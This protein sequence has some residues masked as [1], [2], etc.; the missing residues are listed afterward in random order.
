MTML[1]TR[2]SKQKTW[3]LLYYRTDLH[4]N[5]FSVV[6][7]L[8]TLSSP[9]SS[10][11]SSSSFFFFFWHYSYWRI[12]ASFKIFLHCS[13][14]CHLHLQFLKPMF[15]ISSPADSSHLQLGFPTCWVPSGL[16]TVTFLQ[17]FQKPNVCNF[18]TILSGI[19]TAST[20]YIQHFLVNT[21]YKI[22]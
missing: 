21:L 19:S 22:T 1:K 3:S 12:L 2:T 10:S 18:R 16:R 13:R 6:S 8:Y 7:V 20:S 11:S 15:F 5:K 9:S 4:S 17:G 14:S